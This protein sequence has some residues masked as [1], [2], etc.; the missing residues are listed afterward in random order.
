MEEKA[1]GIVKKK[2][3]IGIL[4]R[5]WLTY[6]LRESIAL[7]ERAAY[8]TSKKPQLEITKRKF[9]ELVKLEIHSK[10]IRYKNDNNLEYFEKIITHGQI[11]CKKCQNGELET[12]DILT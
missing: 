10:Y 1:F 8:H 11:L 5:N 3:E 4:L 2:M 12:N 6:L 7:E 9:N